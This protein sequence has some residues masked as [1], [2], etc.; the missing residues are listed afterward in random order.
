MVLNAKIVKEEPTRNETL[1]TGFWNAEKISEEDVVRKRSLSN[2][3]RSLGFKVRTDAVTGWLFVLARLSTNPVIKPP[4]IYLDGFRLFGGLP[5]YQ[6][7][8]V[9]EVY[10][11]HAGLM[12][13]NGGTLF[14]YLR[15]GNFIGTKNRN[16]FTSL[17]AS[18]GFDSPAEFGS[19]MGEDNMD[20]IFK[21]YGCVHWE[22]KAMIDEKGEVRIAFR[23]LGLKK[24]KVFI[25]GISEDGKLYSETKVIELSNE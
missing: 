23:S 21:K 14:I 1:K 7:H 13:S 4:S 20:A 25:E 22:P 3:L 12:E 11:E 6:L 5:D 24:F 18:E 16:R 19:F 2:Y 9:D 15:Q 17:L 8:N 10:Y